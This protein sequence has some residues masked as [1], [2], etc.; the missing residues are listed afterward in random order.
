MIH[1]RWNTTQNEFLCIYLQIQ[2]AYSGAR[3]SNASKRP[4]TAYP[5]LLNGF[6]MSWFSGSYEV[7]I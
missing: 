5:K 3:V 7:R 4:K 2:R 1:R 6:G